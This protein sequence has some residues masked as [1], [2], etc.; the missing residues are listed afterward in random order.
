MKCLAA[1]LLG[2]LAAEETDGPHIAF[3]DVAAKAGLDFILR[4]GATGHFYQPEIMLGGVAAFDFNND[5]CTDIFVTN[6]ASL[7]DGIKSNP[8]YRN[9][10]FR[11]NC[12][13]TFT[14]VTD[15]SGLA[16]EGFS[17]G[18]GAGDF[19]NDG[20][21]DL[22]VTGLKGNRL[23]RNRGDGTFEDVTARA[24]V[25]GGVWSVSAGWFDYDNDGYLDLFVTNYVKWSPSME[26]A[27]RFEGKL[28]YCHPRGYPGLPNHL[29]HNNHDG[30][31]TDVST[32]SGIAASIGRG[33]GLAFGDFNDDGLI[34][35]FV[36]N[37]STP[38]FLFQNLGDGKFKEIALD[39]GVAYNGPGNPVAGMGVDFRD[40]D[41]DGRDDIALDAMYWDGFTFYRNRGAPEF[42]R[43]ETVASGIVRA[44]R[45]LTGWGM[46]AIDFDNDG[47]K[48]L[49]YAASHFPGTEPQVHSRPELPNVVLRNVGNARF[50]EVS[51]NLG[52]AF[53]HGVAFA[54]FDNDGRVDVVVTAIDSPLKLLHNVS[55][56]AGHWIAIRP[57]GTKSNREGLGAKV[58]LTLPSGMR[59][60]NRATAS[61]GYASSSEPLVRFGLGASE[62][63]AEIQ[64]EW[65]GGH[66]QKLSGAK[67]DQILTVHESR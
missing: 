63:A 10:L 31:F 5:G 57:I 1:L 19:D 14:D 11:N 52:A 27:C 32:S 3:E 16:G 23:Y 39:V 35:V 54:D 49:F 4:N 22:L 18:A 38:N 37:D 53:H 30:T 17:M 25:G 46:G 33:M 40:V 51:L 43:D 61:V 67:A 60:Y 6:G 24:G 26:G 59:L 55:P 64:I 29:F 47:R 12:D 36:A 9:R 34:D 45:N 8:Q 15:R 13:M 48:D 41:D 44:T 50:Q 42:F 7:P 56:S 2:I 65:P 62:Y 58:Q 66:I 20:F 28:T 21:I